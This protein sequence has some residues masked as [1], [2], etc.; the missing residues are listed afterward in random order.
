MLTNIRLMIAA[1]ER[2][3]IPYEILHPKQ[4]L[5]RVQAGEGYFFTN[6]TVPLVHQSLA[7]ILIDK[8]YTYHVIKDQIRN[9]KTLAFLTPFCD[10]Q[11]REY[12]EYESIAAI[13]E[14]IQAT[15]SLP[16]IVKKNR[17]SS[18]MNVFRCHTPAEITAALE[19]IFDRNHRYCDYVALAQECVPIK[20]EY[21]AVFLKQKLV[22][23]YEKDN[24]DATF[25]GNLSPLH[26]EGAKAVR[27]TD[28]SLMATIQDFVQPV[29]EVL[30]LDYGGFD[31]AV[32]DDDQLWFIEVN[33]HPNYKIFVRDNGEEPIIHLFEQ[34]LATLQE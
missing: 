24:H 29:F 9:P 8:D 28:P 2:Q 5:V 31:I 6:Y 16:V 19:R 27:I 7:K 20:R 10:E 34:L 3:G 1:C 30:P 12:L 33:S 18:G 26:W 32:D 13:V 25:S 23:I 21:R 14:K 22:L 15:F 11:Y 17:G 4:N